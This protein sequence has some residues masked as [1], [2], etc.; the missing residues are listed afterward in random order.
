MTTE[1]LE[2]LFDSRDDE[3]LKFS[4]I[5]NKR[6]SRPDLHAFLLL[7]ELAPGGYDMVCSASHDE[8]WLSPA[9][10]DLAPHVTEDQVV[11]LIR[12]GVRVSDGCLCMFA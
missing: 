12:C 11:E 2:E 1:A 6:S 10:E 5:E 7:D 4:R 8:I 9:L 3:Y